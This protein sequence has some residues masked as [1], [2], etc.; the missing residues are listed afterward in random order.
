MY[1]AEIIA[2]SLSPLG[3]R[4][5]TF[6]CTYPRFIH[7]EI[8]T[9]RML[10]R[11]SGSSRA[12]PVRK[13]IENIKLDPFIPEEFGLNKPGMSWSEPSINHDKALLYWHLA[14]E[15]TILN[16]EKLADLEI[17]KSLV[18]R[19][20]E[21]FSWIT[22]IITATD[23]SN[24]FALR[25]D[26]NAQPEFRKIAL[27]MQDLY[28]ENEPARLEIGEWHLPFLGDE[29]RRELE[30]SK[31]NKF[32]TDVY[33]GYDY[34]T[35]IC[36]A[37]A[38]RISYLSHDGTRDYKKDLD[39]YQRLVDNGHLSPLEHIATPMKNYNYYGN[40]KGWQQLRKRIPNEYDFSRRNS[41][42]SS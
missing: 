18:N 11:N 32:E 35:K 17:H 36:S 33:R 26:E 31:K 34:W 20:L 1:K 30:F 21:P 39:L 15:A 12:I 14:K 41:T 13:S 22:T 7:P 24:F 6:I 27:M 8:L 2:D 3:V 38:A 5:T 23:W 16:A 37:R 42:Q 9:H 28:K 19:I 25:T 40:F 4:L 10:S 29:E